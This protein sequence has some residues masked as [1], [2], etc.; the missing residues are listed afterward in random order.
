MRRILLWTPLSGNSMALTTTPYKGYELR[1]DAFEVPTL[2]GYMSSLLIS[3]AGCDE[4]KANVNLF[5][6][7]ARSSSG[8]FETEQEAIDAALAFGEQVVDGASVS[9]T[10]VD[11]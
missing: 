11:L 8:L 10:G 3:R 5:T 6:T 2:H 7:R 4:D 1:A 9:L